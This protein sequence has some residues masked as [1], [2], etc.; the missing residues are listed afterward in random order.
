MD[1][2]SRRLEIDLKLL[3]SQPLFSS[4]DQDQLAKLALGARRIRFGKG[5]RI[6]CKGDAGT[7]MFIL[8]RGTVE[9]LAE[10][11]GRSW[12]VGILDRRRLLRRNLFAHRRAAKRYSGRGAR[13]RSD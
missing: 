13:L 7:S 11:E 4:L 10:K 6:I 5:E 8:A 1:K 2:L 12:P 3:A 9:V